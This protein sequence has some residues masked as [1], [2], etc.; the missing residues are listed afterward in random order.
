MN[1]K[2]RFELYPFF[3]ILISIGIIATGIVFCKNYYTWVFL[4]AYLILCLCFTYFKP[5]LKAFI[6]LI[7]LELVFTGI[8]Y[9]ITKDTFETS[10]ASLRTA[11]AC[12]GFI[13][14]L[15]LSYTKLGKNLDTIKAPR[16]LSLT[17]LIF[18]SF[19]PI[20]SNET[21]EIKKGMKARGGRNYGVI[22]FFKTMIVPFIIR[23]SNMS[24]TLALS[25]ELR[26]FQINKKIKEV[27]DPIYPKWQDY[28][29]LIVSLALI[30]TMIGVGIWM[31]YR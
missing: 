31:Q 9:L 19:L 28:I 14:L 5:V 26:G 6:G 15:G 13:T 11:S 21:K 16:F 8:T 3:S 20:L 2:K 30:G 18:F 17:I 27:Y 7:F 12:I 1:N 22:Y 4:G 29:Y 25:V 23:I 10:K 24:D